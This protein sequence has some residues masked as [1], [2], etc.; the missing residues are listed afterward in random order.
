MPAAN[1]LIVALLLPMRSRPNSASGSWQCST[2]CCGSGSGSGDITSGSSKVHFPS[3]HVTLDVPARRDQGLLAKP[4]PLRL[5]KFSRNGYAIE[6]VEVKSSYDRT[7]SSMH[8]LGQ[9]RRSP[10]MEAGSDAACMNAVLR[11]VSEGTFAPG[12]VIMHLNQALH[13]TALGERAWIESSQAVPLVLE[14][15][16]RLQLVELGRL[17]QPSRMQDSKQPEHR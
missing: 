12:S 17:E 6:S 15:L 3:P 16:Q 1:K 14:F 5:V 7:F 10:D 4:P 9:I 2:G 11:A 13:D 8:L